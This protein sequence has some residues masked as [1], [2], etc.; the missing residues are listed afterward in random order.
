[1][2][3]E[4]IDYSGNCQLCDAHK[5]D[6][7][8]IKHLEEIVK[9]NF[10]DWPIDRQADLVVNW[11]EKTWKEEMSLR[12]EQSKRKNMQDVQAYKVKNINTIKEG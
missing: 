2:D 3:Y 5:T 8:T 10:P 1:M 6:L 11:F 7:G 9:K 4:V 12:I